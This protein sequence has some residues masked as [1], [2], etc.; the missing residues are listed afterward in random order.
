M[1]DFGGHIGSGR[2]LPVPA[3]AISHV[4]CMN[5]LACQLQSCSNLS[6]FIMENY[7][8]LCQEHELTEAT[9]DALKDN[10]TTSITSASLLTA[11]LIQKHLSL[12]L[13]QALLLQQG[14]ESLTKPNDVET[15]TAPLVNAA[16]A[17]VEAAPQEANL[18]ASTLL[19]LL[20]KDPSDNQ[21]AAMDKHPH[22][23][24]F[25]PSTCYV[26]SPGKLYDLRDFITVMPEFREK[27]TALKVGNIE[28]TLPTQR[29]KLESITPLQYMEGS[30]RVMREI[31]KDG[32]SLTE[33]LQ[34]AGYL[35]KIANMGQRFQWR[36]VL[37]Y[38][39]EYRKAQADAGFDFGAASTYLMQVFLHDGLTPKPHATAKD[40]VH[41]QTKYDPSSGRPICGKFNTAQGC[42]LRNCKFAHVCRS[43]FKPHS[44]HTHKS[45]R[46][47]SPMP[48]AATAAKNGD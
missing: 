27:S 12:P 41:P 18:D 48:D 25:D 19:Q 17:D 8:T 30:L 15:S 6:F 16:K 26:A 13:G 23:H 2:W 14:I 1:T 36:T 40:R 10:R 43:C 32:Q 46:T 38:D 42:T 45:Q 29:P 35:I 22:T 20:Q 9:V 4:L 34:Y 5:V 3:S 24:T 21:A 31:A 39:T 28:L 33:L 47:P 37:Q 7:A 11:A 44:D